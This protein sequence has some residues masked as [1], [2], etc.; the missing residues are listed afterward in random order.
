[1][2]IVCP[3]GGTTSWYFDSPIDSHSQYET[4]IAK[5]L[6][7]AVDATYHTIKNGNGRA[8]TGL[9]MGGHGAF[10][11][12]FKHP[13]IWGA[14]GSMSGGLDKRLGVYHK[15]KNLWEE[16]SVINMIDEYPIEELKIIFDC[17][18][19]DFFYEVNKRFENKLKQCGI[20]HQFMERAGKHNWAYWAESIVVHLQ[21]FI[22][23]FKSTEL[24]NNRE[25][26]EQMEK[27][28]NR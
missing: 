27:P 1:L 3:N 11:L 9:S 20:P 22:D 8:I 25:V 16:H 21:F 12:A 23:F 5:E 13:E 15:N 7:E 10:Y 26:I 4:Y 18:T 2:I 24:E 14:A 6:V 28:A 19:N 17:G